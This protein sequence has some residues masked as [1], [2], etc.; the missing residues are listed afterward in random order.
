MVLQSVAFFQG[1]YKGEEVAIKEI[2]GDLINEEQLN[3]F[4]KEAFVNRD[5]AARNCLLNSSLN[6]KISDFGLSRIMDTNNQIYSK[7]E[8]GNL[9]KKNRNIQ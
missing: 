6:I 8:V 9:V 3:E 2:N 1:K 4:V 7:S 5:L